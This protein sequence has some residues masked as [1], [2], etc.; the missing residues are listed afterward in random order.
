MRSIEEVRKTDKTPNMRRYD[1]KRTAVK[2]QKQRRLKGTLWSFD[3]QQRYAAMFLQVGPG[4]ACVAHKAEDAH[5]CAITQATQ[6]TF[7][8]PVSR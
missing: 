5:A 3:H 1:R 7:L 2:W 4:F 6:Y 8:P